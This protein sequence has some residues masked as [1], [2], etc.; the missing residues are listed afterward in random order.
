[1]PGQELG[2]F[3]QGYPL[4]YSGR[5]KQNLD[6]NRPFSSALGFLQAL[7]TMKAKLAERGQSPSLTAVT[8]NLSG[9]L[10]ALTS[11]G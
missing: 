2:L 8:T 1:M 7:G 5:T 10:V 11:K 4:R 3:A 6:Y 9:P